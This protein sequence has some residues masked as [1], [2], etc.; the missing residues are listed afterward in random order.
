[1]PAQPVDA[2]PS[3]PLIR[4]YFPIENRSVKPYS[5]TPSQDGV[6]FES[7]LASF[8][9]K[10]SEIPEQD[11]L[12]METSS[13]P[14]RI[15]LMGTSRANLCAYPDDGEPRRCPQR[16]IRNANTPSGSIRVA[17]KRSVGFERQR[18]RFQSQHHPSR[19]IF[20]S[21]VEWCR[22][23]LKNT[24]ACKTIVFADIEGLKAARAFK[25]FLRSSVP[26]EQLFQSRLGKP[27]LETT[28]LNQVLNPAL[29]ALRLSKRLHGFRLRCNRRWELA[30]I[31]PGVIRRQMGTV[32]SA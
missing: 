23:S 9:L 29:K 20:G 25:R 16:T 32:R 28:I 3:N 27:L 15:V 10:D 19:R 5:I 7:A 18:N 11:K 4:Q 21:A 26:D 31:N 6:P 8:S 1:V 17:R 13:P 12:Q 22:R 24:P 30:G 14:Q 2:T